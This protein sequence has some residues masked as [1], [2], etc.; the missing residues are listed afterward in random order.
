MLQYHYTAFYTTW[1][2]KDSITAHG[3][4]RFGYLW[5]LMMAY[6]VSHRMSN[7][8]KKRPKTSTK[9][10][11]LNI[12]NFLLVITKCMQ[13]GQHKIDYN[14]FWDIRLSIIALAT[15]QTFQNI[16]LLKILLDMLSGFVDGWCGDL[17]WKLFLRAVQVLEEDLIYVASG[18]SLWEQQT[19]GIRLQIPWHLK[20]TLHH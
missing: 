5:F 19:S 16:P 14:I 18:T 15:A 7:D 17:M 2:I 13:D 8:A 10:R 20:V 11:I 12:C 6:F 4:P 9:W 1:S 3:I